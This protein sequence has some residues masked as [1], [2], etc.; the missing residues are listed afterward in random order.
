[1]LERLLPSGVVVDEAFD[2][3]AVDRA[4]LTELFPAEAAAV[5]SAAP[6]RRR[7]FATVRHCA[8]R[9]L[10]ELGFAPAPIL[11]GE[12]GRPTWPEGV[13]GSMTHCVGYRGAAVT[14]ANVLAGLGIDA[15]PHLALPEE[16]VDLVIRP[17]EQELIATLPAG[18]H[19][20]RVVFS[21]KESIFK[22]WNPL[23]LR[24]LDFHDALVRCTEDGTYSADLLLPPTEH[25]VP[26]R[27]EGGW[28]VADG[29]ILS[30]AVLSAEDTGRQSHHDLF[31][32]A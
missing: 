22:A 21:I 32:A 20:D 13:I 9:A 15:E 3:E 31:R 16:I 18:V 25:W 10:G 17:E 19:W 4:A 6:G 29:L 23:T 1:M 28:L 8:R 2:D 24:W 12:S 11:P 27:V 26:T 7:E 5:R 14:R 30:S